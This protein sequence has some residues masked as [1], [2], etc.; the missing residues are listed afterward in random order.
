MSEIL[1][2]E[3]G[4][5]KVHKIILKQY[6]TKEIFGKCFSPKSQMIARVMHDQ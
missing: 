5:V 1:A 3:D 6:M 2:R 4:Y